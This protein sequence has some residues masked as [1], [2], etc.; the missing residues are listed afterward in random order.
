MGAPHP[1]FEWGRSHAVKTDY[2][3]FSQWETQRSI[4]VSTS[5]R[6][7]TAYNT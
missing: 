3:R 1:V 5:G 6:L 2:D 7:A 4:F